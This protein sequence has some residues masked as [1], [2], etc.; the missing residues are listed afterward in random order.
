MS[1]KMRWWS[2]ISCTIYEKD[3]KY[4]FHRML[5]NTFQHGYQYNK[6]IFLFFSDNEPPWATKINI[7]FVKSCYKAPILISHI[8]FGQYLYSKMPMLPFYLVILLS[9]CDTSVKVCLH[10]LSAIYLLLFPNFALFKREPFCFDKFS[11]G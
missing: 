9:I 7:L 4:N 11:F 2:L 8:K 5:P 3:K 6:V 1:R 10:F